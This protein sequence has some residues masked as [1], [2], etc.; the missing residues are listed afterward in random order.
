M[1]KIIPMSAG[2]YRHTEKFTINDN[3][4]KL[5][6]KIGVLYLRRVGSNGS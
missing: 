2:K 6:T 4:I 1:L 5:K 3:A